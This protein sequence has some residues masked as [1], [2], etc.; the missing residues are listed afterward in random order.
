MESYFKDSNI[1]AQHWTINWPAFCFNLFLHYFII[2][3]KRKYDS[4]SMVDLPGKKLLQLELQNS[5]IYLGKL[6]VHSFTKI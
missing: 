3:W 6:Y 4:F 2:E 5:L 1:Y